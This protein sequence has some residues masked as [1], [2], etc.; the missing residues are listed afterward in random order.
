MSDGAGCSRGKVCH[1]DYFSGRQNRKNGRIGNPEP[2]DFAHQGTALLYQFAFFQPYQ[3]N[4]PSLSSLYLL[5]G[6]VPADSTLLHYT[7]MTLPNC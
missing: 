7:T 5:S 4:F 1:K 6:V 3:L 2:E